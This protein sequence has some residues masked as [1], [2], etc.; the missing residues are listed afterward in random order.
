MRKVSILVSLLSLIFGATLLRGQEKPES[1]VVRLDPA[2]DRIVA[3]DVEVETLLSKEGTFEGPTW[4]RDGKS[5]YLIFSDI[6]GG[7]MNK[8]GPDD[9]VSVFRDHIFTRGD[10]A[11]A[12]RNQGGGIDLGS[13]GITLDRQGRIVF[14]NMGDRT[15]ERIEKDGKRTVLVS[16]YEGKKFN[17]PNDLVVKSDGA[18]YFTDSRIDTKRTDNDPEK[19]EPFSGVY[20]IKNGKLQLLVHDLTTPNGIAFTADEKHLYVIEGMPKR[21]NVYDVQPDD[22]ITNRQL[23]IDMSS[24]KAVGGPDGMRLDK[25]GNV[26]STGPGGLWIISPEGKHIGTILTPERITNVSFGGPDGKTLYMTGF[27][28]LYRVQLKSVGLYF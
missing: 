15:V 24:D 21:I 22:T 23:L 25:Q 20:L 3:P 26:Y 28:G 6:P 14:C 16:G 17:T 18:I 8:L 5:G 2:L 27:M 4:V 7:V 13:N 9:K 1:I 10:L 11:L 19:G 12:P